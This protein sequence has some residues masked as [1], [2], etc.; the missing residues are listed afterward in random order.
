[1]ENIRFHEHQIARLEQRSYVIQQEIIQNL[2]RN[3][4]ELPYR[5]RETSTSTSS[6]R[7]RQSETTGTSQN[8]RNQEPDRTLPVWTPMPEEPNSNQELPPPPP[9][10]SSPSLSD[11]Y[12][13]NYI[14]TIDLFPEQ[15]PL[16]TSFARSL[17]NRA[18]TSQ[19]TSITDPGSLL[20]YFMLEN[21]HNETIREEQH[22]IT[23][24]TLYITDMLY[25][26]VENPA[27]TSCPIQMDIFTESSEVSQINKCKHL[28]CRQEIRRWLE[29]HHTCPLCRT[30]IDV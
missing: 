2:N 8:V 5:L 23:D 10:S 6:N 20:L 11:N 13:L 4:R 24:P 16:S 19:Q 7:R 3:T 22:G 28:F 21:I 30:P 26:D 15:Q 1:M 17:L 27:N 14:R 18:N 9:P 12:S 25:R 29:T